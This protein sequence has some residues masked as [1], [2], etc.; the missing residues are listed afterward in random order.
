MKFDKTKILHISGILLIFLFLSLVYYYPVLEGKKLHANDTSV[1]KASAKEIVQHREKYGEEP[2]WTNALFGGMP[3]FQVSIT[4]PGNLLKPLYRLILI[5]KIPIAALL[6]TLIGFFI[7]LRVLDIRPWLAM[8]G[9]I[10]YAFSSYNFIILAAGH[11]TKAYAIS[12]MAPLIAGIILAIRKNRLAGAAIA[13]L[14]LAFQ[15]LANHFQITYYTLIVVVIFGSLNF[16]SLSGK[17]SS[18]TWVNR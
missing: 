9:S 16:I 17:N 10:A 14:F 7:L 8:A 3:A 4:Y 12:F 15:I 1:W 6:M 5:F 11:N 2:L 18:S 13:G